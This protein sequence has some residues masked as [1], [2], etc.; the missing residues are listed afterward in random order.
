MRM[1]EEQDGLRVLLFRLD[2]TQYRN[3]MRYILTAFL[4]LSMFF[5]LCE[6]L[7]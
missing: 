2:N 6:F 4:Y 3:D 7:V 1:A 5:A